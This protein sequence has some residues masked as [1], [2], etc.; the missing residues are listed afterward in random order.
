MKKHLLFLVFTILSLNCYSQITYD[1]GYYIN[2]SNQKIDGLIKNIDWENNPTQF[3]FKLSEKGEQKI[4]NIES[5]KEFGIY[6]TSKY[7][8]Y[9]GNIDQSSKF[10]DELSHTK[11]PIF[12]KE[13]LF[14]KVMLQ[15][16]ASLYY[17]E[18]ENLMRYF[19]NKDHGP[20]EQLIFK[21]YKTAYNKIGVNNSFKQQ[22]WNN[23]KCKN[24]STNTIENID[25]NGKELLDFFI[26]YNKC[27]A[28]E[29]I[30]FEQKQ[31]QN[32]KQDKLNLTLRP[33]MTSTSLSINDRD[34]NISNIDFDR[35]LVYRFGIELELI[36]PF[37]KNKWAFIIEPTHQ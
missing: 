13:E 8:R 11:D 10:I 37:N 19:F 7:V 9:I 12:K 5:V 33:G 16:K 34:S 30:D 2:N 29:F 4:L 18:D 27:S 31:K 26:K 17:F 1:K 35:E 21:K 32:R 20:I 22:L 24:I 28:S 25:Y 14:L 36:L 23:L 6:N 3:S 15:G